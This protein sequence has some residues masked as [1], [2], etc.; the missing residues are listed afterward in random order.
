MKK[1]DSEVTDPKWA[2]SPQLPER[3]EFVLS[4]YER[5]W[6]G[7]QSKARSLLDS[8]ER[9]LSRVHLFM[10]RNFGPEF[11][12]AHLEQ[13]YKD[14]ERQ[15]SGSGFIYDKQLIGIHD[16]DS[17]VVT[18]MTDAVKMREAIDALG[19]DVERI[20][21][22]GSGW[23]K[24][25]FNLF[26]FGA[27]LAAEY[28]AFELTEAGKAVTRMVA[29]EAAPTM[30][31]AAHFFDYY[32]PDFSV[33]KDAK[34][35]GVI[36]HHSIEQ[37]PEVSTRLIDAILAIPG[38]SR[39]VH[40]EPCGFQIPTNNWLAGGQA[41]LMHDIDARNRRFSQKKNQNMNLYPLLRDYE[42]QGKIRIYTV[43][44]YLTSHLID[45]AT[46]LIVWG[47]SDRALP[48]NE[49]VNPRRDDLLPDKAGPANNA[50]ER[51]SLFRR[52]ARGVKRRLLG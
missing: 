52:V 40:L 22:L 21:E 28:Y 12:S 17:R 18:L 3:R 34:P 39:C 19:L 46:T 13:K 24:T 48:D 6:T 38:F 23:G 29:A 5:L 35:T 8:G 27:P 20:V 41:A 37:I 30:K 16:A 50:P 14:H 10:R 47:P 26:R 31:I 32:E 25:S 43:R 45:N 11:E 9:D 4:Q 51:R 15:K 2:H 49:L 44:K 33:L 36:T 42:R 7:V 1:S